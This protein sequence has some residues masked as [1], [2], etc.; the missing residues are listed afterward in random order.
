MDVVMI[1]LS[2][3]MIAVALI[4]RW[5]RGEPVF[6]RGEWLAARRIRESDKY[7]IR[8]RTEAP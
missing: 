5:V 6:A 2:L 4:G 7:A 1:G 8:K 3:A